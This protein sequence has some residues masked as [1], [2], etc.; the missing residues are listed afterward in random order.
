MPYIKDI[1]IQLLKDKLSVYDVIAPV[2]S[3][4]RRGANYTGCCPFHNEKSPSFTVS[5]TKGIFKCFGCGKSGDAIYFVM[6]HESL[7]YNEAIEKL[8]N[9][10]GVELEYETDTR[11]PEEI[12]S[13]KKKLDEAHELWKVASGRYHLNLKNHKDILRYLL[14]SRKLSMSNIIEWQIGYAPGNTF[15]TEPIIKAKKTTIAEDIGLVKFVDQELRDKF[16][17]RITFPIINQ[18]GNYIGIG[19]RKRADDTN[20][21]NPKYINPSDSFV[22]NKSN[23]LYGLHQAITAKAFKKHGM[24]IITEGY[25]DV[26]SMHVHGYDCTVATC[27]TALTED[28]AKLLR[29]HTDTVLIMRDGD[30]AGLKAA[31]RDIDILVS[32]GFKTYIV[33]LP[34]DKD[35]DDMAQDAFFSSFLMKKVEDAV[36]WKCEFFLSTNLTDLLIL[37]EAVKECA[38]LLAKIK[39]ESLRLSY[40]AEL[41]TKYKLKKKLDTAVKEALKLIDLEAKEKEAEKQAK[42]GFKH[43]DELPQW[44]NRDILNNEGFV[45]L[46]N[47]FEQY[48]PGIY[49]KIGDG[50][51]R[52]VTNFTI[53]PLFHINE[54]NNNRR[55]IEIWNGRKKVIVEMQSRSLISMDGFLM[56]CI[57]KGA[58]NVEP[59]FTKHNFMRVIGWLSEA[60]PVCYELKTLGWQSEGFWSFSNKV[61][62]P[63]LDNKV[64]LLDFNEMGIVEIDG[65]HY[66][67]MGGSNINKDHRNE[68]NVYENDM[69]LAYKNSP[70]DF[71]TWAQHFVGAYGANAPFGIAYI[72][73]SLFKDI[74]TATT[75][76]PILY[77]YGPKGSGKSDFCESILW[78]FFSGKN[79]DGKLIQGYNLNPGQGTPF[80]FFNLQARYRN[81]AIHFNEFD[82]NNIEDWKFGSFKAFYD[83]QGR[84]VGDGS[85]GK[86]RKTTIQKTHSALIVAGQ[87][88]STRDDGS[89]LSRSIARQFKTSVLQEQTEDSRKKHLQLKKWEE[90]GLS[91]LIVELLKYRKAFSEKYNTVFWEEYKVLTENIKR[92]H[93][94]AETRLVKNYT[95]ILAA[96]KIMS[97]YVRFPFAY[98]EF[99]NDCLETVIS[100]NA[101]L[102][103]N[104]SL[105]NFWKGVEFLL[106]RKQIH[107]GTEYAIKTVSEVRIKLDGSEET[108]QFTKPTRLLFVR[109]G[110]LYAIY[111]KHHRE[112]TGKQAQDESTLLKYLQDQPY[113]IGLS[114]RFHFNDKNTSCYVLNYEDAEIDLETNPSGELELE[115]EG[116]DDKPF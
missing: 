97:D 86:A 98:N 115:M 20:K 34:K 17:N 52:R 104:N 102:K 65:Q 92:V 58:F 53:K 99:Y 69:F 22:Y 23:V 3:L 85:T 55:L 6:E 84:E 110:L 60:M 32:A 30:G 64:D 114:P 101:L 19:A 103:E 71:E 10:Y 80:S 13:E 90:E 81:C 63:G 7:P 1:S 47:E 11:S 39:D 45:Q 21:D 43:A 107:F 66:I 26:I 28:Q 113:Y 109:F 12:K 83:G 88:L 112:K 42:I 116:K 50:F 100:H 27:G 93:G 25:L 15:I 67:S 94:N 33:I 4:K 8:A 44:V 73:L 31:K 74:V 70:T 24:A 91:S 14:V 62:V 76:C 61:A 46:E 68:D 59:S 57:E 96:I 38:M 41:T 16:Y 82:E 9:T 79:S 18:R 35:A 78:F 36:T 40:T 105:N 48:K 75:K 54:S 37:N 106:D 108:K 51:I 111:A 5:D 95:S 56:T 89:V 29:K 2:V 77:A 87:Y 72:I 49:F